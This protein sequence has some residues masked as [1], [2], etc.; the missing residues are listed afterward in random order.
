MN[1]IPNPNRSKRWEVGRKIMRNTTNYEDK[2]IAF[3]FLTISFLLVLSKTVIRKAEICQKHCYDCWKDQ[4]KR[5]K[6]SC[7]GMLHTVVQF[8]E[9]ECNLTFSMIVKYRIAFYFNT[10]FHFRIQQRIS[11]CILFL[12]LPN[13]LLLYYEGSTY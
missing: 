8:L 7:N 1:R 10:L 2:R 11:P 6:I 5:M 9:C 3:F 13:G 4:N 12:L